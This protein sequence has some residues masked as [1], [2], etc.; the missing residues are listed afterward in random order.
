M[1]FKGATGPRKQAGRE[2]RTAVLPM[3][4]GRSW[5]WW[6]LMCWAVGR[7]APESWQLRAGVGSE[8]LLE[9][10]LSWTPGFLGERTRK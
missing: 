2:S 3:G 7:K 4:A 9:E 6:E 5:V 8:E 1:G 10:G